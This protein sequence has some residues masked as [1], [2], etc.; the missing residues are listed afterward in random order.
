MDQ[1]KRNKLQR[2]TQQAR[3]ILEEE[4]A[5]QLEGTFDVLP[6]G[7]ILPEPGKHLDARER[8]T[9]RKLVDAIGHIKATGKTPQKA[10]EEYTREAAFTFLNRF[11]A[12]RMLEA[13]DILQECVSKGEAS[14][15]FKEFCGLAPG[16]SSLDDGGY[17]LY[18]ECLFDE[19]SVEVKVLFDRRDSASLLWPRRGALAELLE[20]LGPADLTGVWGEDETIGWVYQYF[21]SGEERKKM[22]EE[23]HAPRNSR[24]LA[25]RNQFFTPRYV[26]EFLTDNTLGRIWYEMCKGDTRLIDE[27]EYLVRRPS[28]VFLSEGQEPPAADGDANQ[29]LSQEELLKKTAYIPHRAKKDPRDLK[30]LD[31]ACGSGHFLLYAFDLLITIYDE[32]WYDEVSPQSEFTGRRLRDDYA[33]RE[34]LYAALPGLVLGRNLHG[35][36][37]DP[38]AAQIAALALWMRGQ[39][40]FNEFKVVPGRRPAVV[41]SNIVCAEPM[42]GEAA[43]LDE[44]IDEH[45]SDDAEGRFLASLVRRVFEAMKL[46]GEAGSLLKIEEDIAE[47]VAKAKKQWLERPEFK[48]HTLFDDGSKTVQQKLDLTV[49]IADESFWGEAEEHIYNALRTYAE[50]ADADSYQRRLFAEDAARGFAFIDLC[51]ERYDVVVMN[52]PFG[53]AAKAAKGYFEVA[54][55]QK[56][57][58]FAACFISRF[59]PKSIT[60]AAITTRNIYFLSSYADWRLANLIDGELT[61]HAF[62]D[63]G[64]GVLDGAMVEAALTVLSDVQSTLTSFF[65]TNTGDEKAIDLLDAVKTGNDGE[66]DDSVRVQDRKMFRKLPTNALSYWADGSIIGLFETVPSF[67]EGGNDAWVGL[68]TNDDFQWVRLS[69]E[70]PINSLHSGRSLAQENAWVPYAKGASTRNISPTFTWSFNGAMTEG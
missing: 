19:L 34:Q 52:P 3:R 22:R 58:D 70:P 9:R 23:S 61:L 69:W 27:C 14:S 39:R 16:L 65:R 40:A 54:F 32:A 37:I 62:A 30:I 13:R 63:L 36:D 48:Q 33:K 7:K 56:R 5:E 35:I 57:L 45:L 38:R 18:L 67:E 24:E 4:F 8:L 15:G 20:I 31:P 21:N 10:V 51:R 49:G 12:L 44:F 46:A 50:Q 28:E 17:R 59:A 11:V 29:D 60:L 25:V 6:N 1:D 26:V 43:F 66:L 53:L 55:G 41:R 2:A 64:G 42:P 47:E 68:Q